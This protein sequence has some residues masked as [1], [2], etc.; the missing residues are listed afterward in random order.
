[1]ETSHDLQWYEG[2][3]YIQVRE[4]CDFVNMLF[5][6]FKTWLGAVFSGFMKGFLA[7][8]CER[9]NDASFNNKNNI[10]KLID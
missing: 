9:I 2:E 4:K 10:R 7:R 5:G 3:R 8:N 1:M 6:H